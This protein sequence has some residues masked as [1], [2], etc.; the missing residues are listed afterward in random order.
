MIRA[1][2]FGLFNFFVS[3]L[4]AEKSVIDKANE[5]YTNQQ[6]E[7]SI[8]LYEQLAQKECKTAAI[9]FNLGNAYFKTG[10]IARAIASF[11]RAKRLSPK[12]EDILHN[13]QFVKS[14]TKDKIS[15]EGYTSPS[16]LMHRWLSFLSAL[17]WR[18]IA[19][20]L[21]WICAICFGL[22]LFL[23]NFKNIF[24]SIAISGLLIGLF[25]LW[26]SKLQFS[27]ENNCD[28][29]VV[30]ASKVFVKSAPNNTSDDLFVLHEGAELK[31][32]DKVNDYQ[33]VRLIDGKTG[34]IQKNQLIII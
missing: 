18:V 30:L 14:K 1:I 5:L 34:W 17:E 13:L 16:E 29:A 12:D 3:T 26:A 8:I 11:E 7:E 22:T 27:V 4:F 23:K 20:S 15:K 28:S 33:K 6:F 25:S 31:V 10:Q 2:V 24:L 32:L 9:H 19:I 21:F